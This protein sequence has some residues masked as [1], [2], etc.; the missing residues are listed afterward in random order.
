MGYVDDPLPNIVH[1]AIWMH[2]CI[3]LDCV[4]VSGLFFLLSVWQC[5][6]SVTVGFL[7]TL[8]IKF[9][10]GGSWDILFTHAG[11]QNGSN[12]TLIKF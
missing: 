10:R 11:M 6:N 3:Q 9:I 1:I 4:V 5:K 12:M 2:T 8:S 7:Y